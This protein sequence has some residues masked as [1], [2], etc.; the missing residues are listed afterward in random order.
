MATKEELKEQ[1][2]LIQDLITAY[3]TLNKLKEQAIILDKQLEP[4]RIEYIP[5]YPQYPNPQPWIWPYPVWEPYRYSTTGDISTN[6]YPYK[7]I[8]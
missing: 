3:E 6:G 8:S 2:K 7:E 5:V 4:K 1:L